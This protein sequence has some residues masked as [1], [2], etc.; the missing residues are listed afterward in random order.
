MPAAAATLYSARLAPTT[1]KISQRVFALVAFSSA[2][3]VAVS[4]TAYYGVTSIRSVLDGLTEQATP[5]QNKTY[6]VQEHTE[7]VLG[8]LLR[9]SLVEDASAAAP[10]MQTVEAELHVLERLQG[11]IRDIDPAH[12][13]DLSAFR[14][15][16]SQIVSSVNQRLSDETAY[17]TQSASARNALQSAEAAVGAI[18][19]TVAG[20]ETEAGA[21]ADRAQE[22]SI[23]LGETIKHA[24]FVSSKLKD[25][26]LLIYDT[27]AVANRFRLGP[28]RERLKAS[29]DSMER[30]ASTPS[31]EDALRDV[32]STV[33][34][35]AEAFGNER[36]GLFALRAAVLAK[37][38]DAEAAYSAQRK[39]ILGQ[40]DEQSTKLLG[41]IDTLEE[42]L[43]KQ[44]QVLE[45]A[46]KLRNEP[47][48]VVANSQAASL[49]IRDMVGELRSLMLASND[50]EAQFAT[51]HLEKLGEQLLSDIES[52]RSALVRMGRNNLAAQID[53]AGN[54]MKTVASAIA[55]VSQTKHGLLQSEAGMRE[56]LGRLKET[57]SRQTRAGDAQVQSISERQSEVT[58]QVTERVR[59]SLA[60]IIGISAAAIALALFIGLHT[61]R[62]ITTRMTKA[63]A[64]AEAVSRGELNHVVLRGGQDETGRLL[65]ALEQMVNTLTQI[66]YRIRAASDAINAGSAS[67]SGGNRDLQAHAEQQAGSLQQTAASMEQLTA[68]V[69]QS[70]AS[71]QQANELAHNAREAAAGGGRAVGEIVATM[72]EI[73]ESSRRIGEIIAVIDGISFQTN[74]LALNA[75]VEAARAGAQGRGFAVVASEVRNLAKRSAV[76]AQEIKSL[77]TASVSK[78]DAGSALVERAGA[79]IGEMVSQVVQV[80]DLIAEISHASK[81]QFRAL[82]Q[83]NQTVRSLG[84]LTQRNA[85]LA[86][87][88]TESASALCD[89]AQ[90]L[91]D[92]VSRFK[93][94]TAAPS[95]IAEDISDLAYVLGQRAPATVT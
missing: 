15:A 36:T 94:D 10:M 95:A 31:D 26:V 87:Q 53:A 22:A 39:Q 63:V 43:V 3:L 57:A 33:V 64:V 42:H 75:A 41:L 66:V 68:T 44:R 74:I 60:L 1:V 88:G 13:T 32:R 47:G 24:L 11:E 69:R 82:D 46:L 55:R 48:G 76:A 9:L 45:A 67:I 83:V 7:R 89:Q 14:A 19:A 78:V 30:I 38:P 12:S 17:Q 81:E 70:V 84:D 21:A 85:S 4:G 73:Q 93:I 51:S 62:L 16:Q 59:A 91:N 92:A 20:I 56:A 40:I 6:E 54:A 49:L 71:A 90:G 79:R 5:L 25:V 65:A 8:A 2:G 50:G 35:L 80:T 23:R 58:R 34:S 72:H 29:L 27:D 52:M 37:S 86:Q 28:L 61:V 18:R 77:I